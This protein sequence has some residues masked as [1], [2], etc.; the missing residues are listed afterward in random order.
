VFFLCVY[1]AIK[2]GDSIKIT[3]DF[4]GEEKI[5]KCRFIDDH[6]LEV[7]SQTFHI[8]EFMEKMTRA[9]N[10]Y[11]PIY[12]QEPKLNILIA[13]SNK[14]P[15]GTEIPMT[16]AALVEILGGEPEIVSK[17]KFCVTVSGKDGNGTVAV[18]GINNG[19]LTSLHPYTA[20]SKKRE[21]TECY[22]AVTKMLDNAKPTLAERLE[23][24]KAKAAAHKSA[25]QETDSPKKKKETTEH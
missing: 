7:G 22:T 5:R 6:H 15:R 14:P 16:N 19:N 21:L 25:R 12:D 8:D 20:Q 13:E 1:P 10:T 23:A 11:E 2:D 3:V 4:D 17:D 9:G 24:G 18:L